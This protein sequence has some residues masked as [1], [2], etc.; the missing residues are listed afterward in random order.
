MVGVVGPW[1]HDPGR[2][3][4]I[5]LPPGIGG[6]LC[7]HGYRVAAA[8]P[9]SCLLMGRKKEKGAKRPGGELS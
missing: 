8:S 9:D 7:P 2:P 3:I 6:C 5:L 1:L 4:F